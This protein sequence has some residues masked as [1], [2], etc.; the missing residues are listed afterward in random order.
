MMMMSRE[1]SSQDRNAIG[2]ESSEGASFSGRPVVSNLIRF[3]EHTTP[4]V[5]YSQ[6]RVRSVP[7]KG[8][9][10]SDGVPFFSLRDLWDTFDEWSAYGAGVPILFKGKETVMQ[11]YVPY[12]SAIQLYTS[13][14]NDFVSRNMG[15]G[16]D[17]DGSE[18][19]YRG[20]NWESSSDG[21]TEQVYNNDSSL[22][23]NGKFG[24][25]C[26]HGSWKSR[27]IQ[28]RKVGNESLLYEYFEAT[29]PS[30]RVPLYD[31]VCELARQYLGLK[32][33]C[34]SDL[35]RSSWLSVA[36]YPIYRIPTGPTLRDLAACFLTYHSLSTC[37]IEGYRSFPG[38]A[39][40][41]QL[42]S[43]STNKI[44]LYVSNT[45]KIVLHPF[46]LAS[47]KFR[48]AVWT[49]VAATDRHHATSLQRSA[50][51]WLKQLHVHHP[52]FQYFMS[53]RPQH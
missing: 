30:F 47:H 44:P 21:E 48:G 4:R 28:D 10:A 2:T 5:S 24:L 12:L 38:M 8:C 27:D 40:L 23:L 46:G 33:L 22:E 1:T 17:S 39:S 7:M 43:S 16:D 52:D 25:Q 49:S 45:N 41:G 11:Y 13:S 6:T 35:S 29:A 50:D 32:M 15:L 14:S 42:L 19:D 20:S 51:L 26:R 18:T 34:S 36:W 37:P 31:K 9:G 3:L 53:Q